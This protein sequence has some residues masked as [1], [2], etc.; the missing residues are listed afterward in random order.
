MASKKETPAYYKYWGKADRADPQGN[1]HLLAYHCLD[2]AAVAKTWWEKDAPLRRVFCAELKTDEETAKSLM[3]FFSALHDLGK[4]DARFQLKLPALAQR[5]YPIDNDAD[6]GQDWDRDTHGLAGWAWFI[7]E[8]EKYGFG[9]VDYVPSPAEWMQTV[10]GHHGI[11]PRDSTLPALHPGNPAIAFDSTSR[12][13]WVSKLKKMFL[14]RVDINAFPSCPSILAGFCS[15]CD[16]LGSNADYFPYVTEI[17]KP[18]KY[19]NS[20]LQFANDAIADSGVFQE[21]SPKH[22]MEYLFPGKIP[23]EIQKL[24]EKLPCQHGLTLIEAPTGS[25][26]T[27][28]ALAYASCLLSNGFGDSIIFALPTQATSNAMLERVEKV[29][30]KLFPSG[31]NAVLAHGKARYNHR[32]RNLQKISATVTQTG[33]DASVQ[34]AKWLATSRKR[35]F[36]GQ[37]GICTIDQVLLSVLP[38]RH[39][40][41]RG[42]GIQK[43][44]VIVDEIHA[45]D[46]YMNG[47]LDEVIKRQS[48]V[49]GSIILLSATLQSQRR[50]QILDIWNKSRKKE[51]DNAPYPLISNCTSAG[52]IYLSSVTPPPP[53][54]VE[55]RL[56]ETNDLLP[57][58][59]I[60]SEAVEDARNG[61]LIAIVCNLVADAQKIARTLR[62]LPGTDNIGIDLFHSRYRFVERD[63]L[64]RK[65]ISYYGECPLRAS[66]RILVA[67]QV[68]EQSLNLDFDRMITQICPIDLLFQRLGRLHRLTNTRPKNLEKSSCIVLAPAVHEYGLHKYVYGDIRTLWRTQEILKSSASLVFPQAYRLLLEKVYNEEKWDN[69][70]EDISTQHGKF[71][72]EQEG[73]RLCAIQLMKGGAVP[74]ADT[75]SR[76][77]VLTR[78]GE[79]SL[80][81]LPVLRINGKRYFLDRTALPSADDVGR[82]E[83]MNL[84]SV[85]VPHSWIGNFP[86][87]D[88]SGY[89]YLE[90]RQGEGNN[91]IAETANVKFTYDN[92]YG[93]E[94]KR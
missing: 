40:F 31:A 52:G 41:V 46:S 89:R 35:V 87:Y 67:T 14:K 45:Y 38:I 83:L 60:L 30:G 85:P 82:D 63:V 72:N 80:N 6:E 92:F 23:Y 5:L 78:D 64:E 7:K 20:R 65:I 84:N 70:P 33:E 49:G 58:K 77:A 59:E 11:L 26:K 22:G 94:M 18:E 74:F 90:M 76:A 51:L 8:Q 32:F 37:I 36:L 9:N 21:P 75:D 15:I 24:I 27:E 50:E 53:K 13:E 4:F 93:L 81:L 12:I 66:K 54:E 44:V 68:I 43:S 57:S 69:E 10:A 2:V 61:G 56:S 62:G 25:G 86:D 3:L 34:C 79:M 91:W 73:T 42:F 19:F 28:A 39:N 88:E 47:L 29:A 17:I 55:I 1:Y 71:Q 48:K 16:W